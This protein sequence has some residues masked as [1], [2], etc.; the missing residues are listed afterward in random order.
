MLDVSRLT[1]VSCV[2]NG[3]ITQ[4]GL[5]ALFGRRQR[6]FTERDLKPKNHLVSLGP[7]SMKSLLKWRKSKI[8][9]F[10]SSK[11]WLL[12]GELNDVMYLKLLTQ[13]ADSKSHDNKEQTNRISMLTDCVKDTGYLTNPPN[14]L[15]AMSPAGQF[16]TVVQLYNGSAEGKM[17]NSICP[18]RRKFLVLLDKHRWKWKGKKDS[19][20]CPAILFSTFRVAIVLVINFLLIWIVLYFADY[21]SH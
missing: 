17:L 11:N 14:G 5:T 15:D 8:N 12:E 3:S 16:R 2:E 9:G 1:A 10:P 4:R 6:V 13:D 19:R 21:R 7:E 20:G 18:H